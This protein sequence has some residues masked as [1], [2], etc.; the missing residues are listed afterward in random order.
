MRTDHDG[1]SPARFAAVTT[2]DIVILMGPAGCGK[3]TIGKVLSARTGWALIEGD[4]HH[5][6]ANKAKQA[7]GHP[8]DDRDR[9]AW[10]DA[11]VIA[12]NAHPASR[13]VL[14]CSALTPYVQDRLSGE[15][16]RAC[17][18]V[19]LTAP[20]TRLKQRLTARRDH[21][22]PASLLSDQLAALNPPSDAIR[23][24]N[25]GRI[26]DVCAAIETRLRAR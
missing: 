17:H 13:L 22:M 6:P 12:A 14:A 5:P 11:L 4:D 2:M 15:L 18:W 23:I 7:A 8:L 26:E 9:A 10:I 3:S 21:F 20:E 25:D 1:P 19:L 24:E 16:A